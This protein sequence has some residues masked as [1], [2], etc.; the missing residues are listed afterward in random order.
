MADSLHKKIVD[1]VKTTLQTILTAN[2]YETNLGQNVYHQT[3]APLISADLIGCNIHD[4][5]VNFDAGAISGPS[6]HMASM[7][8]TVDAFT[9]GDDCVAEIYKSVADVI[10]AMGVDKTRG[11]YATTTYLKNYSIGTDFAEETVASASIEFEVEFMMNLFD[12]YNN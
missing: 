8:V 12:P 11:N 5:Q 7:T 10:K 6:G 9:T 1:N 4:S 3:P 2:S